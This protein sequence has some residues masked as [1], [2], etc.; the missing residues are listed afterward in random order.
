MKP[1]DIDALIIDDPAN[2]VFKVHA[3]VYRSE[4]I[5]ELEMKYIF[6]GNWMFVGL[7]AQVPNPH[8]FITTYIGRQN[9]IVSR[10]KD[11]QVHGLINACRHRG[12]LICHTSVGN[13]KTHICPYHAW[14]YD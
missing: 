6:E 13:A 8:D 10:D 14:A 4:E 3:D 9:V 7:E 1:S 12:A 5:F 11:G 2:H